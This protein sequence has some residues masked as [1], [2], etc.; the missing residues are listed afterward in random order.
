MAF[1]AV[2]PYQADMP[3]I[4]VSDGF[5]DMTGYSRGEIL[6]K[7]CRFLRYPPITPVML[8]QGQRQQQQQQQCSPDQFKDSHVTD[9]MDIQG[10]EEAVSGANLDVESTIMSQ[11]NVPSYRKG[12]GM[13]MN[14]VTIIP[15]LGGSAGSSIFFGFSTDNTYIPRQ[16]MMTTMG[17]IP[18]SFLVR[19]QKGRNKRK[20]LPSPYPDPVGAAHWIPHIARPSPDA[21]D[22]EM[23]FEM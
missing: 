23:D 9:N 2:D 8:Q 6:G 22:V 15:V 3:V 21:M 10:G 1:V 11:H 16:P 17:S 19:H 12:G 14:S 18:A 13:F 4:L 5:E 7:N 20:Q